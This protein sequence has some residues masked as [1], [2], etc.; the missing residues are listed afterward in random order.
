MK[1]EPEELKKARDRL[2]RVQG[3]IG[4]IVKMLDEGR[5]CTEIL[6][7]LSAASTALTRAGFTIIATGMA[8]C[9]NNESGDVERAA[10]EKAFMSLA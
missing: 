1:I 5:D 8:Q 9:A 6:N 7:Q 4:G 3:Q 10:L 2:V